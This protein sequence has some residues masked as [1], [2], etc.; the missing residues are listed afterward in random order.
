M[1][2]GTLK[3]K[4]GRKSKLEKQT[5]EELTKTTKNATVDDDTK[6]QKRGRKPKNVYTY[7][8]VSTVSAENID[9]ENVI[10]CLRINDEA[11]VK[12][13]VD[14]DEPYAYNQDTYENVSNIE[15]ELFPE[16][17]RELEKAGLRVVNLLQDF[18][19]KNKNNEWPS[20]TS[21]SC[22]WCAHGFD[23]VPFGIPIKYSDGAF[24]VCGCYCS[25][26]CAAASN[27]K[28]NDNID[29]LWER[30]SLLNFLNRK[31]GLENIVTPAPNKLALKK[32]GGF[33]TIEKFR[34]FSHSKKI[35]NTNYPPMTSI[36]LQIEEINEYE[37]HNDNR[38]IPLDTE[39]IIRYKEKVN[40]RRM[41]PE[42]ER[43]SLEESMNLKYL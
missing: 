41:K 31:L 29:E 12:S 16:E 22:Y 24:S 38:Y 40:L 19:E 10:V 11:A 3:K 42:N 9:D 37:L 8:V 32:F 23:N 28:D 27:F 4:R 13:D 2:D 39:R 26:E 36:T 43:N 7:D 34:E 15:D 17:R 20:N 21:I 1:D 18:E 30:Y 35:I 14:I 33:L 5:A 6:K 25:L